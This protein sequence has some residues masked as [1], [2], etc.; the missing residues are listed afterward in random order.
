MGGSLSE[1]EIKTILSWFPHLQP[2]YFIELGTFKGLS[3]RIASNIFPYVYTIEIVPELYQES[4]SIS[5]QEGITN[6]TYFLGDTIK[7]LPD[8]IPKIDVSAVWFCDAHQSGQDTGNNGKWVPLLDEL[9]IILS[10][11]NHP[12]IY[13]IDDVRLFSKY[14][15]W[16]EISI[17]SIVNCFRTHNK[18]ILTNFSNN[19]RYIIVTK[20]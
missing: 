18:E 2:K 14:W 7:L 10:S 6:I 19:D 1:P 12:S 9:N 15:D 4:K 11:Y 5:D 3:S 8:L 17:D 13:I 16:A 20:N